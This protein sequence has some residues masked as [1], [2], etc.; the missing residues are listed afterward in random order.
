MIREIGKTKCP[1]S[2]NESLYEA[3]DENG[4]PVSKINESIHRS[5]LTRY[6][7]SA[8]ICSDDTAGTGSTGPC[9]PI[10]LTPFFTGDNFAGLP[11]VD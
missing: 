5:V 7:G 3:I 11:V 8:Q 9:K 10:N 2:F 6:S 1:V 4:Q